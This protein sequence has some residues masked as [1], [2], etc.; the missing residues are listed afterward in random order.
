MA[1]KI[2]TAS[3]KGGVGKSTTAAAIGMI[4]S[5]SGLKTL[6]IDCDAGLGSIDVLLGKS[7]EAAFNWMD[8]YKKNCSFENA[9]IN[10]NDFLSLLCAP[11]VKPE[12]ADED[13]LK[14]VVIPIEEKFDY[15]IFDAPAGIGAGLRRAASAADSAIIIATA[16]EV[17]VRGADKTDAI[18]R[19]AGI[20]ETRLIINRYSVKDAKKGKL[21]SIDEAINKTRVRL[22]GVIPED[23]EISCYSVTGKVSK[24]SRSL[25][26][27]RRVADR[28]QGKNVKLTLSLIK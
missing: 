9:L 19:D 4:L 16:D 21:L 5:E 2:V 17:S 1:E 22:L 6:L 11:S 15:I 24:K 12:D 10:I 14:D 13:C 18:L 25:A 20:N 23:K 8:V 27:F 7:E 3:G 26:A 28:I